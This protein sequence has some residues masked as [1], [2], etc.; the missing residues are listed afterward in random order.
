M[1]TIVPAS[2]PSE[3]PEP[4]NPADAVRFEALRRRDPRF[5]GAFV[6]AVRTTGIYCRPGCPSRAPRRR[7]VRFFERPAEARAAGYRA[8]RRCRPD[9]SGSPDPAVTRVLAACRRIEQEADGGPP[10]AALAAEVGWSPG[11]LQRAFTR[12]VGISPR[13]YAEAQ[14]MARLKRA[15]R[16]G[17]PVTRALYEAGFGSGSRLYERTHAELGTTPARYRRGAPG[18]EV[19]YAVARTALGWLLVAATERGVCSV[20]LGERIGVLEAELA[21]ELPAARRTRE[22]EGFLAR[23]LEAALAVLEG[24]AP[25]P[26]LPLDVRLTAFARRVHRE[27]RR[28]PRGATA[29]YGEIA[30]RAGRP[31]AARAVARVCARNP[32]PLLVPCHRVVRADGAPGGYRFG[33]ARKR[34]LLEA[35]AA[36]TGTPAPRARAGAP[37]ASEEPGRDRGRT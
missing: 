12:L 30:A 20:R 1:S 3:T 24:A 15:L 14:R 33:E 8:C 10:L 2:P 5:A 25:E 16:A 4:E 21:R 6:Y 32:V 18:V 22:R 37:P 17:E 28:L 34:A 19:R 13:Q 23:A 26:A 11:H 36:E 7:N 29:S 31:A 9:G 27:I 35:E